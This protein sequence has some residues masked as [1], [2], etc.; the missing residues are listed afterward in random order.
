[1]WNGSAKSRNTSFEQYSGYA[2]WNANVSGTG[3]SQFFILNAVTSGTT[4]F[5]GKEKNDEVVIYHSGS[6]DV[7][8]GYGV[9]I[10]GNLFVAGTMNVG[11]LI[12]TGN[13][14]Y[15]N[16]STGILAPISSDNRLKKD[17]EP[18]ND[19][20]EIV[21][22]LNGVYF[23]WKNN[24]DFKTEDETRQI[25]LIAQDV[26]QF[27][28]EAVTLNG[29]KDYKTVRYSEMVSVLIEAIK[30]QQQIIDE[31]KTRIT[32]IESGI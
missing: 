5:G 23:K 16:T 8:S 26:E 19:A 30:E 9:A 11:T 27:L 14:L 4:I 13:A 22:K 3:G 20:L 31:L 21:K 6:T 29:V 25:G 15:R 18:I 24:D 10:R 7:N 32:N 17:I 1:L 12:G 28:P 2:A